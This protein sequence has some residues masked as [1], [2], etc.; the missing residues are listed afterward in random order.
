MTTGREP[1]AKLNIGEENYQAVERVIDGLVRLELKGVISRSK[2]EEMIDQLA[3]EVADE[4][5]AKQVACV[6]Q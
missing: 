6:V 1:L 4:W 5:L 3:G 2:M